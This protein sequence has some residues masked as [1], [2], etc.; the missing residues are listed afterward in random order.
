MF[1]GFCK[2][3][4]GRGGFTLVELMVVVVILAALVGLGSLAVVQVLRGSENTKRE[5]FAR[6]VHSAIMAYKNEN[7]EWPLPT[8]VSSSATSVTYGTVNAS[9]SIDQGNAAVLMLLFGRNANG[10]RDDTL[11]AYLTDSSAL[12]VCRGTSVQLLDDALAGGSIS[13]N[14]MIGFLVTMRKTSDSQYRR[15]S[16][17][18]AFAPVRITFDFELDHYKVEVPSDSDF[19]NVVRLH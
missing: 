13:G 12:Y 7:G 11:R 2:T 16:Q 6:T 4:R 15:L 17:S 1:G 14:D 19:P 8:S 9:N 18:R 10:R 3:A 5:A